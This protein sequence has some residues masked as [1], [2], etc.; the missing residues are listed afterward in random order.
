MKLI[1]IDSHDQIELWPGRR[2]FLTN[3]SGSQLVSLPKGSMSAMAFQRGRSQIAFGNVG[4]TTV[5]VNGA[6]THVDLIVA[7]IVEMERPVAALVR[8]VK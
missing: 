5:M 4:R 8:E 3:T 1:E 6:T 2:L 7:A